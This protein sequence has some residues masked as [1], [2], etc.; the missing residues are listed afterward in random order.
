MEIVEDMLRAMFD[1]NVTSTVNHARRRDMALPAGIWG[2]RCFQQAERNSALPCL[3]TN[4]YNNKE[5]MP[6]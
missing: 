1:A 6:T 2:T 3:S 5:E 4:V